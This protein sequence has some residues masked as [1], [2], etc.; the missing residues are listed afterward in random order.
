MPVVVLGGGQQQLRQLLDAQH[1]EDETGQNQRGNHGRY[2]E[3]RRRRFQRLRW[4]SKN[5]CLSG[6]VL[7]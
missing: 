6:M 5:I 4:G 2:V 1:I 7:V 3:M